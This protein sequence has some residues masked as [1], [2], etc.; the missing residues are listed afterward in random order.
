MPPRKVAWRERGREIARIEWNDSAEHSQIDYDALAMRGGILPVACR[1]L[2]PENKHDSLLG[3]A[4]CRHTA[5]CAAPRAIDFADLTRPYI[6]DFNRAAVK[7][8]T[9]RIGASI[10]DN[11]SAVG[12]PN[13]DI[14]ENMSAGGIGDLTLGHGTGLDRMNRLWLDLNLAKSLTIMDRLPDA[15]QSCRH[16]PHLQLPYCAIK[17]VLQSYGRVYR[18]RWVCSLCQFQRPPRMVNLAS[19]GRY[20]TG[21]DSGS[22]M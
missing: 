2:G 1:I 17:L 19:R 3:R 9:S 22:S 13:V 10:E 7:L 12:R 8:F 16:R 20:D 18:L 14:R 11:P 4:E 6:D 5:V 21:G 15:T